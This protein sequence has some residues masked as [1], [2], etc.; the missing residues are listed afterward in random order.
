M[1]FLLKLIKLQTNYIYDDLFHLTEK[2]KLCEH[3]HK[4]S[5]HATDLN[6]GLATSNTLVRE[7][8]NLTKTMSLP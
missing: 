6:N 4:T 1:F 7:K 3:R 8:Y 2:S 5:L